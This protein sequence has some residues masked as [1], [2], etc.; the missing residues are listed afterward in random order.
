M[1]DHSAHA[2][3]ARVVAACFLAVMTLS[4]PAQADP[5]S[6]LWDPAS[7]A[8][9]GY[10]IRVGTQ[11][12]TYVQRYDVG[13]ATS[14]TFPDAA[15]GQ[16]YCFTVSAY[17]TGPI[18]GPM[19][20][21]V[22]GYSNAPPVLTNPGSQSSVVGQPVSLQLTGSDPY[23]QALTF[24]ATG[25]PPGLTLASG[26]GLV[27][28][29]GSTAGTYAVTAR[30]SDG[31]LS[32]SQ[33]FTWTMA[34]PAPSAPAVAITGPTSAATYATTGSLVTLQGTASAGAGISDVRWMNDRGGSGSAAGTTSWMAQAIALQSGANLLTVVARDGAG[35]EAADVLTVT[36]TIPTSSVMLSAR[37]YVRK[38]K[39][40]VELTWTDCTWGSVAVYRDGV[41]ITSTQNDGVHTDTI[42]RAGTYTYQ[43]CDARNS[44]NCSNRV[45]V[46]F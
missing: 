23:G 1:L 38:T 28:G 17:A 5:I 32:S 29:A 39:R 19:S 46:I 9:A 27:S 4:R 3:R 41:R 7:D 31:T 26:S 21:E 15:A 12:G 18:E 34:P 24:S 6:L 42:R 25:L 22:C 40:L 33:A 45:A 36:Y 43:V 13:L 20:P 35:N 11:P 14:F 10:V 44:A 37:P 2:G 16:Q 30:V 8:V